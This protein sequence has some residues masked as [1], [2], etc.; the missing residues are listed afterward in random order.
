ME[1]RVLEY[2]LAVVKEQSITKA[3]NYLHVSQPNLSRQLKDLEE[4]LNT[5]L[6]ERGSR[7]I[8]LTEDGLYL[9]NR[10]EEILSIVE[11]T[12]SDLLSGETNISGNIYIG[13]AETDSMSYI[14][15]GIKK[16]NQDY[17]QILF[18]LHS[19]IAEDMFDLL[20]KGIIE[21]G[22][23]IGPKDIS[24]YNYI[25]F[26]TRDIT[27]ILM[28]KDS[29][30]AHKETITEKDLLDLPLIIPNQHLLNSG[31]PE[32]FNSNQHYH[33]VATYNLIYNASLLVKEGVGYA[34][35]LDKI[36]DTN[37]ESDLCFR[38]LFPKHE[39]NITLIWKK[40]KP[41]SKASQIFLE[42]IKEQLK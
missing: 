29:P 30:L 12:H 28:R 6:F 10:A 1:L 22:I 40:F 11:K 34:L 3:A 19:C 33:I 38:P 16:I 21:F 15:R 27:G 24:K 9:K 41:L 4:E 32:Y 37:K 23:Y 42:V 8:T 2:F 5:V 25:K 13:C 20:E 31:V 7:K 18:H 14:A 26:P 36:I 17:P 39:S 35:G